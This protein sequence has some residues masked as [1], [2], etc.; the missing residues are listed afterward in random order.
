MDICHRQRTLRA[1]SHVILSEAKD[2]LKRIDHRNDEILRFALKKS[3]VDIF[4][5]SEDDDFQ[6]EPRRESSRAGGRAG[7]R[8]ISGGHSPSIRTSRHAGAA[9]REGRRQTILA[10]RSVGD[11]CTHGEETPPQSTACDHV[12]SLACP[13]L[14]PLGMTSCP[15]N[16]VFP[17]PLT[18]NEGSRLPLLDP[19]Q[20]ILR[21]AQD[22]V[23]PHLRKTIL[24]ARPTA[25][26]C[27][28]RPPA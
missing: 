13:P 8:G 5:A 9:G 3:A 19:L 20:E 27:Y 6:N 28:R 24:H 18:E 12:R 7:K 4:T 2:L 10:M 16:S 23:A 14:R 21:F 26:C 22:D 11:A 15:G 17:Q 1:R 25:N